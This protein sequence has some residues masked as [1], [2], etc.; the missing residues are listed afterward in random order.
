VS[1]LMFT[2]HLTSG[3]WGTDVANVLTGNNKSNEVGAHVGVFN[4]D[5]TP[6]VPPG[7]TSGLTGFATS[8][9]PLT[10]VVPEPSTLAVAGL[11]DRA[12]APGPGAREHRDGLRP[13]ELG[14]EGSAGGATAVD[15]AGAL[16]DREPAALGVG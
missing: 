8:S 11:S 4:A 5:N 15:R 6:F 13:H 14:A 7:A 3:S 10:Q 16:G 1:S 2:I 9:G 12:P